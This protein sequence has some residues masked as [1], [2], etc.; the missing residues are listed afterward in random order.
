MTI[1]IVVVGR[2]KEKSYSDRIKK[3]IKW[4]SSDIKIDIIYIKD[5]Q[6]KKIENQIS[7]LSKL[8]FFN[9]CLSEQGDSLSSKGFSNLLFNNNQNIAF[10]IGGPN[11]HTKKSYDE[12]DKILSLSPMTFPHEMATLILIEQLYRALS[13]KKGTQY[14]RI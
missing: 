6:F 5:S 2:L 8:N 4:V 10:F 9:I 3:Y 14:H 7:K 12:S 1:K 11:G 13:I